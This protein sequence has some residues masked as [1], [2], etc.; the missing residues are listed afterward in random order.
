MCSF[1]KVLTILCWALFLTSC[2]Q[3]LTIV[4]SGN[5][6]DSIKFEFYK[7]RNHLDIIELKVSSVTLQKNINN[8]WENI[9]SIFGEGKFGSAFLKNIKYGEIPTGLVEQM[10]PKK[11]E[12][13]QIYRVYISGMPSSGPKANGG[14]VFTINEDGEAIVAEIN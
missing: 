11:L 4:P 13:G 3:L 10:K 12:P 8:Q 9:W 1:L 5:I 14:E 6:K 2:S 7:S